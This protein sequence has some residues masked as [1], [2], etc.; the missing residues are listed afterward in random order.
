MLYVM[1]CFFCNKLSTS[2]ITKYSSGTTIW[3]LTLFSWTPVTYGTVRR[4]ALPNTP[5]LF[6]L[7]KYDGTAQWRS[8]TGSR[9]FMIL[10]QDIRPQG[11]SSHA[12]NLKKRP[13]KTNQHNSILG[14]NF[15]AT[16]DFNWNL[17]VNAAGWLGNV[18][19]VR[20]TGISRRMAP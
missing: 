15:E 20:G 19:G 7:L 14:I 4:R 12:Q 3:T 5:S 17:L 10:N 1:V 6:N 16:M 8:Y 9:G 2:G 11:P 13:R 18:S